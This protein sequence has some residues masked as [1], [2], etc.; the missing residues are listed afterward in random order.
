MYFLNVY[1]SMYQHCSWI[2][3]NDIVVIVIE[4][5]QWAFCWML[6]AYDVSRTF[7][8]ECTVDG[9]WCFWV[10]EDRRWNRYQ[11]AVFLVR[12]A[13]LEQYCAWTCVLEESYWSINKVSM[14]R[15][16]NRKFHTQKAKSAVIWLQIVH[17]FRTNS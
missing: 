12:R 8:S 6:L 5:M 2:R 14:A 3:Y 10:L 1:K 4:S 11:Q 16:N 17:L 15:M 13:K 7:N 9:A